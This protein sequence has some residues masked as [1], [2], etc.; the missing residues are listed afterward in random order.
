[1]VGWHH[2]INGHE[3]EQTLDNNE[4]LEE[5]GVLQSMEPQRVDLV[6]EQ[7]KCLK[8]LNP[9]GNLWNSL[10]AHL[11]QKKKKIRCRMYTS[12]SSPAAWPLWMDLLSVWPCSPWLQVLGQ[13]ELLAQDWSTYCLPMT[14]DMNGWSGLKRWAVTIWYSLGR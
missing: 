12:L 13:G 14:R 9:K 7:Q 8:Y 1:M 11:L 6:T 3:F 10:L 4:R 5:P 2:Q